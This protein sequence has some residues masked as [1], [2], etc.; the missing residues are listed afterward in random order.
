MRAAASG[1]TSW[2]PG[3]TSQRTLITCLVT[4]FKSGCIW[5][6]PGPSTRTHSLTGVRSACHKPDRSGLPFNRGAGAERFGR[7]SAVRGS[8]ASRWLSHCASK[9]TTAPANTSPTVDASLSITTSS[10]DVQA[11]DGSTTWLV[12]G[13]LFLHRVDH[14]D[15]HRPLAHLELEAELA[16]DRVGQRQRAARVR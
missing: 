10:A 8:E 6:S 9:Q 5:G 3:F 16:V 13:R 2:S 12:V 1:R 15:R 4:S 14:E 11:A 7:P